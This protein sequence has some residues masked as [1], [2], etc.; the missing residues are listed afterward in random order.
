M[1]CKVHPI[2]EDS[3]NLDVTVPANSIQQEMAWAMD[4]VAGRV[5]TISTV[6]KVI[7]PRGGCYFWPGL[8]AGTLRILGD[9]VNCANQ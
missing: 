2:V 3:S 5:H 8:A 7:C 1:A 6:P 4:S 9:I